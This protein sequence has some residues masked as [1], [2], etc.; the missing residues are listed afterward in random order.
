MSMAF[1]VHEL[2]LSNQP[3]GHSL[4]FIEWPQQEADQ[5]ATVPRSGDLLVGFYLAPSYHHHHALTVR[6]EIGGLKLVDVAACRLEPGKITFALDEQYMLPLVCLQF[7]DVRIQLS[8]PAAAA[9]CQWVVAYLQNPMR[10]EL[11]GNS[12]YCD[13]QSGSHSLCICG[14]LGGLCTSD[15][16]TSFVARYSAKRLQ[17]AP[18]WRPAAKRKWHAKIDAELMAAAW[19]PKRMAYWLDDVMDDV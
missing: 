5:W 16:T 10:L 18:D 6:L 15:K 12:W 1:I 11:A 14:G 9:H 3:L 19:H 7:H 13:L 4:Q 8:D 2:W 17:A